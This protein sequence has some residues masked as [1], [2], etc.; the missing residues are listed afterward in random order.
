MLC[1][2][3]LFIVGMLAAVVNNY[4]CIPSC[5][6]FNINSL[7]TELICTGKAVKISD[8]T[9]SCWMKGGRVYIYLLVI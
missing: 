6:M 1:N 8:D 3:K 5:V 2:G 7:V 9:L 4:S